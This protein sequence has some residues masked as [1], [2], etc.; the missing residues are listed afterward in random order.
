MCRNVARLRDGQRATERVAPGKGGI[1]M[2]ELFASPEFL[3]G[4][5]P[6]GVALVVAIALR[7]LGLRTLAIVG[8]PVAFLAAY[9]LVIPV[10]WPA[11]Q[12]QVQAFFLAAGALLLGL[13]AAALGL[14]RA[15][16]W[17]VG[18][19]F[20]VGAL[21]WLVFRLVTAG[22]PSVTMIVTLVA[23]VLAAGLILWSLTIV[24]TN[25]LGEDGDD[26]KAIFPAAM[27]LVASFS[28]GIISLS[29][30]ISGAQAAIALGAA[31]GGYLLVSFILFVFS[32]TALRF[33]PIGR[34]GA[35]G[36]FLAVLFVTVLFS[37]PNKIALGIL[38]LVFVAGP[39]IR[40]LTVR[41]GAFGRFLTAILF[42]AIVAIPAAAAAAF[43]LLT[44][45]P[46]SGY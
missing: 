14:A 33:G 13:V 20:A 2:S 7:A 21:A 43:V 22:T 42:G 32:G 10:G 8:V 37:E 19:L 28:L 44:A 15:L 6:F 45:A 40:G 24:E 29:N 41:A 30:Y 3:G 25:D 39:L 16:I 5:V 12:P 35:G 31:L 23:L 1:S 46:S 36:A 4:V 17:I 34:L 9:Y 18:I 26:A 38:M 27:L 11:I